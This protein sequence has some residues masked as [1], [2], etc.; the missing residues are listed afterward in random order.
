MRLAWIIISYTLHSIQKSHSL[1]T[2][3]STL[4]KPRDLRCAPAPALRSSPAAFKAEK[5]KSPR[6]VISILDAVAKR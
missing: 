5:D 1:F 6:L 4:M 2:H 3:K